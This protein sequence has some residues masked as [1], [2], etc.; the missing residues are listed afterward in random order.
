MMLRHISSLNAKQDTSDIQGNM[1]EKYCTTHN[2]NISNLEQIPS[3]RFCEFVFTLSFT[4]SSSATAF[5]NNDS[6]ETKEGLT[7]L[8]RQE[9]FGRNFHF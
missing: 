8:S 4:Y 3:H 1:K 2:T 6:E 7:R 5:T 9:T